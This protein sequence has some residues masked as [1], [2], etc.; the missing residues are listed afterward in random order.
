ML[1][2][3]RLNIC[4]SALKT[5]YPV[6]SSYTR[7]SMD[8]QEPRIERFV[9]PDA[10]GYSEFW[11]RDKSPI[12]ALELAKLLFGL[13][14]VATFVGRNVGD[15]VWSGME[16][17]NGIALD[18]TPVMGKYPIP[19]SKTDLMVGMTIQ[20]AYRK[21]EWSERIR[22]KSKEKLQLL[23]Q[24]EY[25]YDLFFDICENVYID[26]LSNNH[27]V[28]GYYTEIARQWKFK[29]ACKEF[30]S[31]PTVSELLHVWWQMAANKDKTKYLDGY[32]DRSAGGLVERANLEKFYK[33][34]VDILNKMVIPLRDECL[35]I[36]GVTERGDFRLTLYLDIWKELLQLI[37]FW[38]G[39]RGDRFIL[40][41]MYDEELAREEE[42]KEAVKAT[43][44]SYAELIEN[45]VSTKDLDFTEEVKSNVMNVD[46]VVRIEG[47]DIVMIAKNKVDRKLLQKLQQIIQSVSQR[48]T[49][50][51]RG[52]RSGKIHGRRL[53]RAHT[54]GTVFQLKKN[55][56]ELRNDIVLLIDAS[57][58]MADPNKWDRTER[59]CQTLFTAIH[60]YNKN[61]RIFAYNEAKNSCRIS[62]L[63]TNG[64]MFTV[65]PHG[66]TASGE[67]IIATGLKMKKRNRKCKII[68]ITDG[69]SNWGCGV[70]EAI[71]FCK[72]N[73]IGLMTLGIGCSIDS[74]KLLKEEYGR[75][76]QAVDNREQ[77]AQIFASLLNYE[78][79]SVN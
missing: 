5:S 38:P 53:Y 51:N 65:L 29:K 56:F 18:P 2:R 41:D 21:T 70:D 55:N 15:L 77:L 68:H 13:R 20:E 34:P 78:M 76:F 44:L 60:S 16:V 12:E 75:L 17:N 28:F 45:T 35:L 49:S 23:P 48:K 27:R 22:E 54:S 63:Y 72:K 3:D 31:P 30:I 32:I 79:R 74:K 57:G 14:K 1:K 36:N 9:I 66:K 71:S 67:A 26:C 64:T 24:Y 58:S 33:K 46:A 39:D 62:E 6:M 73:K 7:I 61:T 4:Y 42:G 47:N 52:L 43:I 50:F 25:K 40:S 8:D 37:K 10:D 69:A 59:I 19:A 11:R